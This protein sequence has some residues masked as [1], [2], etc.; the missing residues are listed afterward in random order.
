MPVCTNIQ[1]QTVTNMR[2]E[3]SSQPTLKTNHMTTCMDY[4]F[5]NETLSKTISLSM[6]V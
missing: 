6:R 2:T 4:F 1:M 5:T 3:Y